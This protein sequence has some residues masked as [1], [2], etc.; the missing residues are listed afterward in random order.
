[1]Q[2]LVSLGREKTLLL[3]P[4]KQFQIAAEALRRRGFHVTERGTEDFRILRIDR[5]TAMSDEQ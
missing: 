2:E 1:V 5:G 3:A 4:A